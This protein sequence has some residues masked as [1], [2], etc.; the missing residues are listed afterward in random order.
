MVKKILFSILV[1]FCAVPMA[2]ADFSCGAGYVLAKHKDIDGIPAMECQKLWC[3]DLETGKVMGKGNTANTGYQATSAPVQVCDAKDN[4]IECWGQ[5]R[6]C[7]GNV[8]GDWNPEYGAYTRGGDSVT[9]KSYQKGGCFAWRLQK[10]DCPDG[11]AAVLQGDEWV[12]VVSSGGSSAQR[13]PAI[14]RTGAIRATK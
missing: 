7:A 3:R 5:R 6:W 14:R 2:M 12:C 1:L 11:Q 9:Y 13:A 10:A 8:R 4:C